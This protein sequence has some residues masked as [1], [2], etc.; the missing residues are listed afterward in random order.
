MSSHGSPHGDP[1]Y[2]SMSVM[3]DSFQ[4]LHEDP[5]DIQRPVVVEEALRQEYS[6]GQHLRPVIHFHPPAYTGASA[7]TRWPPG[8]P[9][10]SPRH[11]SPTKS[12]S[13]KG[14]AVKRNS[15]YPGAKTDLR[16][17]SSSHPGGTTT[18]PSARP[19]QMSPP[20]S[21]ALGSPTQ[22]GGGPQHHQVM[23]PS[24]P[25][26][27][28]PGSRLTDPRFHTSPYAGPSQSAHGSPPRTQQLAVQPH[29]YDFSTTQAYTIETFRRLLSQYL[30]Q[31][32]LANQQIPEDVLNNLKSRAVAETRIALQQ[33]SMRQ[34]AN[35][36]QTL[37]HSPSQLYQNPQVERLRNEETS[38]QRRGTAPDGQAAVTPVPLNPQQAVSDEQLSTPTARHNDRSGASTS[39]ARRPDQLLVAGSPVYPSQETPNT[40][41]LALNA[42]ITDANS[43]YLNRSTAFEK[44][45]LNYVELQHNVMNAVHGLLAAYT[46]LDVLAK[47]IWTLNEPPLFNI[48]KDVSVQMKKTL[49]DLQYRVRIGLSKVIDPEL[50][51]TALARSM[52]LFYNSFS[53]LKADLV[54]RDA[55]R[56]DGQ[57]LFVNALAVNRAQIWAVMRPFADDE[58]DATLSAEKAAFAAQ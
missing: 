45:T 21:H 4:W 30:Q 10:P 55:Q 29:H 41:T 37:H 40:H 43:A 28:R 48:V 33:A 44:F 27:Y 5:H 24:A 20:R 46:G 57:S 50:R 34:A 19:P 22:M 14:K 9:S 51:W 36:H 7:D 52:E 35:P 12:P 2:D 17:M 6:R 42:A 32:A 8:R 53:C 15:P 49:P 56:G 18:S 11:F 16:T 25:L 1:Q 13:R 54:T 31:N 58:L 23:E 47:E 3:Q 39:F 38:P 26:S